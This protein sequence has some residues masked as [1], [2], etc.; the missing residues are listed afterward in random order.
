[1]IQ[2]GLAKEQSVAGSDGPELHASAMA[3][4]R[5]LSGFGW[6]D[7]GYSAKGEP[8][9]RWK[10]V[11]PQL[12]GASAGTIEPEISGEDTGIVKAEESQ[13]DEACGGSAVPEGRPEHEHDYEQEQEQV[14]VQ[15]ESLSGSSLKPGETG[16]DWGLPAEFAVPAAGRF[17]VQPDFEVLVP[18]EVPYTLR[19]I[20]AGYAELLHNQDLWSFRLT[21][22]ML[23]SA[24]ELGCPPGNAIAWL[25]AHAQ[26]GCRSRWSCRFGSGLRESGGHHCPRLFCCPVQVNRR[27]E[28]LLR[29]PGCRIF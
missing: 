13:P 17:V 11:K 18:P 25:T 20:L 22:E 12:D 23:E 9:F 28:I 29:I 27:A 4:L 14:Q 15:E 8:C 1:M 21:R 7:L 26:G 2:S 5:C 19:W 3:W 10:A 24:A 6:C 16:A